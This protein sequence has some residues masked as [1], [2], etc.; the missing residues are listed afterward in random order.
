MDIENITLEELATAAQ[1][2]SMEVMPLLWE[3]TER[4][5]KTEVLMTS[6]FL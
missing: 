2:G 6:V 1:R 3:K 5:I 4:L